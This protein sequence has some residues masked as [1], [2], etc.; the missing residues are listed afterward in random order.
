MGVSYRPSLF[1]FFFFANKTGCLSKRSFRVS[2]LTKT[3]HFPSCLLYLFQ[4]CFVLSFKD[5]NYL[6]VTYLELT[7]FLTHHS[8]QFV[9]K[10]YTTVRNLI[11]HLTSLELFLVWSSGYYSPCLDFRQ[12]KKIIPPR[13]EQISHLH[14]LVS[15]AL[16]CGAFTGIQSSIGCKTM[17]TSS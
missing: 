12:C 1:H 15:N 13:A 4:K 8:W 11:C 6:D 5:V 14:F 16:N 7:V 10:Y 3:Y 17:Q 9:S 2:S